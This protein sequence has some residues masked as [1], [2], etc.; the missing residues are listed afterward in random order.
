MSLPAADVQGPEEGSSSAYGTTEDGGDDDGAAQYGMYG[1][2]KGGLVWDAASRRLMLAVRQYAESGRKVEV[3]ARGALDTVTGQHRAW[4]HVRRNFYTHV[5]LL[6]RLL[7]AQVQ[8]QSGRPPS[9][10]PTALLPG[11]LTC[12]LFKD[13]IIAPGLSYD[14]ARGAALRGAGAPAG[15][16]AGAGLAAGSSGSAGST[17]GGAGGG[18]AAGP[19]GL[20]G[21]LPALAGVRQ[22]LRY[23]LAIKK[24][25]QVIKT[26][27]KMDVWA[28]AKALVELE[29]RSAEVVAGAAL[30][31]K[32][33]AYG[34]TPGQDLQLTLGLDWTSGPGGGV[35]RS[36][37]VRVGDNKVAARL[38][39]GRWQL[40]Y[41]L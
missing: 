9:L 31:L 34:F 19:A 10:D 41:S 11:G 39:H 13:W 20:S 30:R 8:L 38:Q 22:R 29:P 1:S 25:P 37:Y 40:L 24:N 26:T 35:R 14:S 27:P 5:P 17:G 18:W 32:A 33:L 6:Q 16:G 12:L 2:M 23:Q 4:G 36:P 7:E 3:K 21:L 15:A 28:Y